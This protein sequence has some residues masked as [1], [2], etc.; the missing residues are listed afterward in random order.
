[1]RVELHY[2]EFPS[3]NVITYVFVTSQFKASHIEA[4]HKQDIKDT[5]ENIE[6]QWTGSIWTSTILDK[7]K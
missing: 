7:G 2:Q 5:T 4:Q 3:A 6:V 1:M